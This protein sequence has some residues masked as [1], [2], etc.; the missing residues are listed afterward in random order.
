VHQLNA[1]EAKQPINWDIYVW[2]QPRYAGK[3]TV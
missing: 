3:K 1:E 2:Q